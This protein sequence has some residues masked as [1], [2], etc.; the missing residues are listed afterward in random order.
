MR[1]LQLQSR[2]WHAWKQ[3]DPGSVCGVVSVEHIRTNPA[4]AVADRPP[5]PD[6]WD[7]D[8]VCLSCIKRL[9]WTM[10]K[11]AEEIADLWVSKIKMNARRARTKIKLE[12]AEDFA[13]LL[14]RVGPPGTAA[15]DA[16]FNEVASVLLRPVRSSARG[17]AWSTF[18][19]FREAVAL[20]PPSREKLEHL[21]ATIRAWRQITGRLP[22]RDKFNT[23]RVIQTMLQV[24]E[25]EAYV[26]RLAEQGMT[27]LGVVFHPN[28]L[29]G[30]RRD[31]GLRGIFWRER[32]QHREDDD[33]LDG[34]EVDR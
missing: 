9:G 1:W 7:T 31:P 2:T 11:T 22:D 34:I 16:I 6:T 29:D 20:I 23:E 18:P 19:R 14:A 5:P 25:P 26:K 3:G 32:S 8:P 24:P 17:Q 28:T 4:R 10:G 15:A 27:P 21:A 30:A 13:D 12:D 33:L